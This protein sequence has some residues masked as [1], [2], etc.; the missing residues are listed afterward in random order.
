M[1]VCATFLTIITKC[2]SLKLQCC[3]LSIKSYGQVMVAGIVCSLI[4]IV[5]SRG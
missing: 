1:N 3:K 2:V 4:C 5:Y